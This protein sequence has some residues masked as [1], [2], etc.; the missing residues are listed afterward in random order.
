MRK[1]IATVALATLL[2]SPALAQS[3]MGS[4]GSGN[5]A[6]LAYDGQVGHSA[7]P[8]EPHAAAPAAAHRAAPRSSDGLYLSS[9]DRPARRG[10]APRSSGLYLYGGDAASTERYRGGS[11][12][13]P[14]LDV[15]LRRESQQGQW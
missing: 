8:Y 3:Y 9:G 15:Q 13:D 10:V 11:G 1:L 5:I 6:P 14:N 7:R 4:V 12:G 2:G